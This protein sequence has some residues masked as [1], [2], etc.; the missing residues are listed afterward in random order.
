MT[1]T[2]MITFGSRTRTLPQGRLAQL[3]APYGR[4]LVGGVCCFGSGH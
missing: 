2:V 4:T 1:I 3:L